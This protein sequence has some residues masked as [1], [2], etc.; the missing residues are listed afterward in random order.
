MI[1]ILFVLLLALLALPSYGQPGTFPATLPP[2]ARIPGKGGIILPGGSTASRP[3]NPGAGRLRYNSTTNMLEWYGTSWNNVSGGAPSGLSPIGSANTYLRVDSA[4]TALEYGNP[5]SDRTTYSN[6]TTV[7]LTGTSTTQHITTHTSGDKQFNMPVASTCPGKILVFF[8]TNSVTSGGFLHLTRQGSDTFH[9][10]ATTY[11]LDHQAAT[12]FYSDGVSKWLPVLRVSGGNMSI[13]EDTV[14]PYMEIIPHQV[15]T[16]TSI[17]LA[18]SGNTAGNPYKNVQIFTSSSSTTVTLPTTSSINPSSKL[19]YLK[20]AGTGLVTINRASSNTIRHKSSDSRTSFT[21]PADGSW[22]MLQVDFTNSRW[23]VIGASDDVLAQ[24]GSTSVF[25]RIDYSTVSTSSSSYTIGTFDGLVLSLAGNTSLTLPST[26]T[27][28]ET[29]TIV[30]ASG[31]AVTLNAGGSNNILRA[32]T[33]SASTV[34]A[35]GDIVT[36]LGTTTTLWRCTSDERFGVLGT[37]RGGTGS[38]TFPSSAYLVATAANTYASRT[39]QQGNGIKVTNGSGVSGNTTITAGY[40][41]ASYAATGTAIYGLN[42]VDGTGGAFTLNLPTAVGRT[43]EKIVVKRIDNNPLNVITID[44]DGSET[45]DGATTV[46]ITLQWQS[47]TL[48][49]DGTNWVIE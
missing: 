21:L 42:K 27:V 34:L 8:K 20:R 2:D 48:V 1:R 23:Y 15:Q 26:V 6:S 31:G 46:P 17:T 35:D 10:N 29:R 44:P 5:E 11:Y 45:I 43:G 38:A 16:G 30:N 40:D 22:A 47:F 37:D 24:F 28:G 18:G 9:G 33:T 7:T 4:G 36:L 12:A 13:P 39:F 19:F 41:V 25:N 49:S 14:S 3:S 32:G